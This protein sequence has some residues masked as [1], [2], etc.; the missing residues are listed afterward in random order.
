MKKQAIALLSSL[1]MTA[2]L[3]LP[4][5]AGAM[6]SV[7]S[8]VGAGAA[9]LIDVPEGII[10]NSLYYCPKRAWKGMA[11]AFGGNPSSDFGLCYLGQQAMG[12]GVGVP[13]GMVW[14]VPTGALAGAKH[15]LG[16]G[17]DKPFSGESFVVSEEK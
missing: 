4:S 10:V 1:A 9:F 15:G 17:W 6:G 2:A 14:G 13:F 16:T 7:K 12:I 8:A 11:T 5:F 3:A